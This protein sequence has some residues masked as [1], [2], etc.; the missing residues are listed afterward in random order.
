M[1]KRG[2]LCNSFKIVLCLY[3]SIVLSKNINKLGKMKMVDN[4]PRTTPLAITKPI[5]LP[6]VKDMAHKAI[7][8]A[9]VVIE[10]DDDFH[11]KI[12]IRAI[13]SDRSIKGYIKEL[14]EQD[15]CKEKEQ[16]Q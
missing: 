3:F 10:L 5:S 4:T 14:L 7:N 6:N 1:T 8:P 15:L 16:T 13:T 12:K 11:K 9:I 2:T